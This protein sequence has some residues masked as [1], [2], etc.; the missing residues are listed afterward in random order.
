[1]WD[2]EG[3]NKTVILGNKPAPHSVYTSQIPD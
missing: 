2:D 3:K 1:M